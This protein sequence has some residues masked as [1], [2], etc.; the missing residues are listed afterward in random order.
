[1]VAIHPG[2]GTS[3]NIRAFVLAAALPAAIVLSPAAAA[4]KK[5]PAG[6]PPPPLRVTL[7]IV[8]TKGA[9]GERTMTATKKGALEKAAQVAWNYSTLWYWENNSYHHEDK[10]VCS[11]NG[12]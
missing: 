5:P 1:M 7:G 8:Q 4:P 12:P 3:M 9:P 2:W 11:I 6:P 10:N